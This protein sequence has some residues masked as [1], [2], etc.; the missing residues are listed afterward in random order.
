MKLWFYCALLLASSLA[1]AKNTILFVGDGMGISTVTAARIF[2]G[3]QAGNPG[4]EHDLSFDKFEHVAL[5]KTYN[6]DAQVADSAGTI[7][8][9]LSGEKTRIGVLGVNA[10]VPRGDC[11]ASL[12]NE[13]PTLLELAEEAGKATGIVSTARITHATPAGTYAH[14][15]NRDWES[16][17]SIPAEAVQLGCSDIASQ[18]ISMP[19]GDGIDVVLGGGRAQFLPASAEDPEYPDKSGVRNDDR[20]L[21]DEWLAVNSKRRYV[22]RGSDFSNLKVTP[23][24]QLLGLFEPS[25]MQFDADRGRDPGQEPSLKDMTLKALELVENDPDGYFLLIEAGRIDHA[26]HFGNAY[27]ALVDT[28]ALDEAVAATVSRVNLEDTLVIVTADHSH[29]FTISGYPPRGNPILGKVDQGENRVFPDAAGKPCTT[30]SYANGPGYRAEYPDLTEVDTEAHN[31]QQIAAVPLAVETHAGE[32]VAAYATGK[33]ASW[34]RGVME[35]N[36]L[37][38]VMHRTLFASDTSR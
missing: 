15:P 27:R 22:W 1:H 36:R 25:H 24:M 2:A 16:S 19:H 5:I 17:S 23:G 18:L 20:N 33:G 21:V 34:I 31:Y 26:H 13:L 32:D 35:Q 38:H 30:L 7:T 11:E 9:M 10:S 6:V 28:V 12:S 29:T 4:E 37:F 8:A 3:Q 14:V